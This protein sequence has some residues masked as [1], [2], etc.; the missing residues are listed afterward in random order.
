[1]ARSRSGRIVAAT[2]V[3]VLALAI[4]AVPASAS[5]N[6]PFN[7]ADFSGYATGN[8]FYA[9]ALD[10]GDLKVVNV[11]EAH[12]GAAVDSKGLTPAIS[13]EMNRVVVAAQAA[14]KS[15]GRGAGL[16]LGIANAPADAPQLQLTVSEAAAP[17]DATASDDLLGDPIMGS[18]LAYAS[19]LASNANANWSNTTACVLGEDISNGFGLAED[20]QLLETGETDETTGKMGAPLVATDADPAKPER[21]VAWSKSRTY[22]VPQTGP[23]AIP[24]RFGLAS[25]VLMTL[26]PITI[27]DTLTIEFLGEWVLTTIAGGVPGSSSVHYGPGD[28]S[29]DTPLV[30]ILQDG[31]EQ[32]K[33][34][35]QQIFGDTGL[36]PPPI[37]GL[38]EL[39]VAEDPRAIDGNAD[40]AP[41]IT[42]TN[43]S[44]A[45]DVVRLKLADGQIGQVR[46]G[47]METQAQV[48]V[49]GIDCG[50]PVF[51]TA[52]PRGVTVDQSFVVSIRI[53]NPFG[54]D[55]T[56][57]KVTDTITTTG[58]AKFQVLATNPQANQVPAGA[59][60]DSGVIVWN[61]I[62]TI[63]K[64]GERTVTTTIRAQGGGGIIRD[65]VDV[66]AVLGN[67]EGSGEG[68]QIVGVSRPLQVPV[69]LR[70][71]LPPTGVG[72]S[73]ATILGALM[74]L[75]AAG[76]AIRQIRRHA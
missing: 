74:L 19:T 10:S 60:R 3:A 7:T 32:F 18:P 68:D 21:S 48:P 54:C 31:V 42:P 27:G 49:G 6:Q 50:I 26:A 40:S 69:V 1:M 13:N 41:T 67:C 33:L 34:N 30:R 17:E 15:Y 46:L 4:A 38:L 9:D 12:T 53:L 22:L 28:A 35:T 72:T 43:A 8:V 23:N 47:H 20:L 45:L 16:E 52:R 73:T 76:V 2:L 24:G 57:V 55:L 39:A 36:T 5:H 65:V 14:K 71:E 63:P 66:S 75:S 70:L 62:G 29:P 44:A 56:K 25:E 61:D 64:G 59:N 51:K 37:E 58:D 11:T